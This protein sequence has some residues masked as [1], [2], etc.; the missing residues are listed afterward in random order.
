MKYFYCLPS[1]RGE[2]HRLQAMEGQFSCASAS[3]KGRVRR[4][5]REA[6][7]RRRGAR[8]H[9]DLTDLGKRLSLVGMK[10]V[11]E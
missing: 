6:G 4:R 7:E 10:G 3:C 9:L 2:K 5:G 8:D 11:F 1:G